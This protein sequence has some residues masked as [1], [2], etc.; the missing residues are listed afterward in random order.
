MAFLDNAGVSYLWSKIKAAL[1]G[2]QD[3]L[4]FDSTPTAGSSNPVTS[5]GVRA[6][7]D[8]AENTYIFEL[9]VSLSASG[10]TLSLP[11]GVTYEIINEAVNSK[12]H[13]ICTAEIPSVAGADMAGAYALPFTK[14]MASG[15]LCF[16]TTIESVLMYA[17]LGVDNSLSFDYYSIER[18][19]NKV[20]SLSKSSTDAQYPTAKAVYDYIESR[21]N[22]L[23]LKAADSPDDDPNV[24]TFVDEG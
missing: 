8:A 3:T 20:T 13:V 4:T 1:K 9:V 21:L 2:K 18:Q 7:I 16:S 22:G 5:D 17:W 19:Q 12:A 24:I 6:A 15:A 10:I 11:E 14:R 23:T